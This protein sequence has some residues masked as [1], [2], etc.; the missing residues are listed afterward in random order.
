MD[1]VPGTSTVPSTAFSSTANIAADDSVSYQTDSEN[2]G[3]Y[4]AQRFVF[5][6]AESAG[7]IEKIAVTWVG[8]GT[9]AGD[10]DGADLYIWNGSNYE[11]LQRSTSSSE[12][13]L[14]GEQTSAHHLQGK[15]ANAR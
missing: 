2:E 3:E 8:T 7:N 14:S 6:V 15:T 9:N 1:G 10:T 11:L 5:N 12:V 4:A 13:T